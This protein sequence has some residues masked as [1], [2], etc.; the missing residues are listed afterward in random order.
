MIIVF[1]VSVCISSISIKGA[2]RGGAHEEETGWERKCVRV[3]GGAEI[4][5]GRP[6]RH[7]DNGHCEAVT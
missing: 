2:M 3:R 7:G 6:C 4:E 5:M 1:W